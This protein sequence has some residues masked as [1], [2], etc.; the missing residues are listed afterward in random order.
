MRA[1]VERLL[2]EPQTPLTRGVLDDLRAN[3]NI[4]DE[5][6]QATL[7]RLAARQDADFRRAQD[8]V[9]RALPIPSPTIPERDLQPYQREARAQAN[10]IIND[11]EIARRENPNT[12]PMAFV[13]GRLEG[14]QKPAAVVQ[15]QRAQS[16]MQAIPPSVRT[17]EGLDAI[18]EQMAA[19]R[20]YR[21]LGWFARQSADTVEPPI[22]SF[23]GRNQPVTPEILNRWMT[24][25]RNAGMRP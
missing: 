3:R 15:Q 17:V 6:Y 19:Y 23:N 16:A 14:A 5:L 10:K 9:N 13:R 8:F 18:A 2:Q 12:D 1:D 22:V 25:Q 21:D 7:P 24:T 4:S 11:L 20:A